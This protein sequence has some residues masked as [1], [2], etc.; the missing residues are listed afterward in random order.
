MGNLIKAQMYQLKKSKG[1]IILFFGLMFV[2]QC[3]AILGEWGND[4]S[5]TGSEYV[6]E[7]GSYM[8]MI[9]LLFSLL[10]LGYVCGSDFIDKTNNYEVMAG[11]RRYEI[12][13][14]RAV[15]GLLGGLLGAVVLLFSPFIFLVGVMGWGDTL[16]LSDVLL[17]CAL[18]LFPILRVSC[19]F[20]F[21]SFIIKNSHIGIVLCYF[22][23]IQGVLMLGDEQHF[24]V[25]LG[26]TNI[27]KLFTFPSFMTYT[28]VDLK[29]YYIY[30][31]ALHAGDVFATIAV[32]T[33]FGALFLYA[34]YS[35]FKKD[36]L[37]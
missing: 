9:A 25:L 28:V 34:G 19:E 3:T 6:A 32:S 37:N 13:F 22:L 27:M 26:F 4:T 1:I 2:L 17:R 5:L 36:D 7:D 20:I 16:Q 18:A 8:S 15:V 11:H 14:S 30:E 23:G 33:I 35:Y 12:Y 24:S 29:E 10:F 21:L 31:S